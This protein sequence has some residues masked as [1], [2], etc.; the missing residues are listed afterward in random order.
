MHRTKETLEALWGEAPPPPRDTG[1]A[2]AAYGV[3]FGPWSE[4]A[5]VVLFHGR[6]DPAAQLEMLA[7]VDPHVFCAPPTEYRMLVKEDL[8]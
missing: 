1:W 8:V 6:F 5:E 2:K 4:A 7:S 3:L